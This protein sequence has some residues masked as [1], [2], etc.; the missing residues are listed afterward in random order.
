MNM[1]Q[2]HVFPKYPDLEGQ[3]R[4]ASL[5]MYQSLFRRSYKKLMQYAI[6]DNVDSVIRNYSL[7]DYMQMF[8][9]A[10]KDYGASYLDSDDEI[11]LSQILL[12]YSNEKLKELFNDED[13]LIVTKFVI[14]RIKNNNHV[15]KIIANNNPEEDNQYGKYFNER[16]MIRLMHKEYFNNLEW[17]K[18]CV[19]D[20]V[21]KDIE[22][23]ENGV[24]ATDIIYN[25]FKN[26]NEEDEK[27]DFIINWICKSN[28]KDL[29]ELIR[30]YNINFNNKVGRPSNNM[31]IYKF[32]Y[33]TGELLA[34]YE[35]RKDCMEKEA[36]GRPLL[37]MLINGKKPSYKKSIFKELTEERFK[38]IQEL[39]NLDADY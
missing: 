15:G 22:I 6:Y 36:I 19:Y 18:N 31:K 38:E 35:N 13:V 24:K 39:Y 3:L 9:A 2:L 25:L 5:E 17:K 7:N 32:H 1:T 37:S 33:K 8:S 28:R 34:I 26:P 11:E 23:L 29:L 12:K 30:R 20:E 4:K 14:D 16:V 27:F 21:D 10:A